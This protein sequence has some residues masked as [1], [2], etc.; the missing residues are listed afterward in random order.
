MHF[1]GWGVYGVGWEGVGARSRKRGGLSYGL[2]RKLARTE[3]LCLLISM[4]LR[5][6]YM[7][8]CPNSKCSLCIQVF[9]LS[10]GGYG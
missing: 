7:S 2:V 6:G 3:M 9:W 4:F 5:L 1:V 10:L 8:M